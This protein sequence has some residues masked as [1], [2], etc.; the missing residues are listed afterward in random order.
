MALDLCHRFYV[1]PKHNCVMPTLT[2]LLA[3]LFASFHPATTNAPGKDN[4]RA[5]KITS[6]GKSN[7]GEFIIADDIK[8]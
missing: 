7:N 4:H 5:G 1:E 6:T 3:L 2:F 8:P